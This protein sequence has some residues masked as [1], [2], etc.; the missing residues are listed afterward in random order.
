MQRHELKAEGNL[1]GPTLELLCGSW[2]CYST[3]GF[4]SGR[5]SA[6]LNCTGLQAVAL[7]ARDGRCLTGEIPTR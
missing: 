7:A 6:A 2:G 5:L 4:T 1:I 3:S